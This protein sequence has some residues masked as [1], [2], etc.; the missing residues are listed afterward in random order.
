MPPTAESI[1]SS[2]E[3]SLW[4]SGRQPWISK[5]SLPPHPPPPFFV[6][7]QAPER[8]WRGERGA[9]Y[10][11]NQEGKMLLLLLRKLSTEELCVDQLFVPWMEWLVRTFADIHPSQMNAMYQYTAFS[12]S[13]I[14]RWLDLEP[15]EAQPCGK[16]TDLPPLSILREHNVIRAAHTNT[17]T[18]LSISQ[19]IFG[20][21]PETDSVPSPV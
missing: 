15:P 2:E 1:S 19:S 17:R 10:L 13:I 12:G 20:L 7:W 18:G 11:P 6:C 21:R 3:I 9:I 14:Y 4:P 16:T 5:A 8:R